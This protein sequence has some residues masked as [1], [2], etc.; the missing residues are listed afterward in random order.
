M[1]VLAIVQIGRL[2]QLVTEETSGGSSKMSLVRTVRYV[3]P[4]GLVQQVLRSKSVI[5]RHL[6]DRNA[7]YAAHVS[8]HP[9]YSYKAAIEFH[10]GRGMTNGHLVAGS[11]PESTLEFCCRS[12]DLLIPAPR[13]LVGL[14]VGNFLGVSLSHFVNYV[15]QRDE[16]SIVV[17]IDPNIQ[18]Q[19]VEAPQSHVIAILNHFGLQKN[20]IISVG[21]S[22][23]K[24]VSNDGIAFVGENGREYDPYSN[25]NSEQSCEDVLG[26]LCTAIVWPV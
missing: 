26:S 21:Y 8:K 14:H 13:A 11:M 3:M 2:L 12:L 1:W 23:H 4:Y 18:H 16:T 5:R 15:R 24:T 17:S 25:F 20:A 7:A 9:P 22:T 6:A 19:G 10:R